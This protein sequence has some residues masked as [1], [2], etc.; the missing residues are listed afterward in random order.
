MFLLFF[1]STA[2][3]V[4]NSNFSSSTT[5]LTRS[6]SSPDLGASTS[7]SVR[8]STKGDETR[9]EFYR[10]LFAAL[11]SRLILL[12]FEG[13]LM[14]ADGDDGK[15]DVFCTVVRTLPD[16]AFASAF[17]HLVLFYGSLVETAS[18]NKSQITI[19]PKHVKK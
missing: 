13:Y 5:L 4:Y 1:I 14:D 16:L 11:L 19:S 3:V 12:L 10:L 18:G 7:A 15:C 2:K 17:L 8:P 6:T 9:L